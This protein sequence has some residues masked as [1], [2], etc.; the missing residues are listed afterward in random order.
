MR[1]QKRTYAIFI[2]H[3]FFLALTR[4]TLD[5][6]TIFHSESTVLITGESGTGTELVARAIHSHSLRSKGPLIAVNSA[7]IPD[8]LLEA[9]LFGYE[10]GAFTGAMKSKPGR[11]A[12]A[13]GGTLRVL[14]DTGQTPEVLLHNAEYLGIDLASTD[15]LVVSHGHYDHTG[16]LGKVLSLAA[17]VHLFL[18]PGALAQRFSRTEAGEIRE[19]G[20]PSSLD[21]T[22]LRTSTSSLTWANRD[23][24]ITDE[25]RVT[26][27]VPRITDFEDTGGNFY[28]DGACRTPDPIQDD[29]AV[30]FDTQDG[31]VVLLG[32]GHS[33]VVN[34]LGHVKELTRGRPVHAVIGGTHLVTA[35]DARLDKTVEALRELDVG[36]LAPAHCTGPR[37]QA[38]LGSEFPD[39]WE[40]CHVGRRFDFLRPTR[41]GSACDPGQPRIGL[42]A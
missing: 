3:G 27:P 6:N 31:T 11:F 22:F 24:A 14:F 16:G 5:P 8:T 18:H 38:R 10:P 9:E 40:P 4:A 35:S 41:L 19:I 37:A 17:G 13:G 15:C 26:G 34:T 25:L 21:E 28:L 33:G 42:R 23:V 2:W 39:R 12:M 30:F 1:S 36:L 29:Q 20:M 32:C 7:G